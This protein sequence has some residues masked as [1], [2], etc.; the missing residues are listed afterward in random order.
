MSEFKPEDAYPAASVL[1]GLR[2]RAILCFAGGAALLALRFVAR[3][4]ILA[5]VAGGVVCAVGVGWLMANNPANKKTGA[6]IIAA[7]AL[8]ALSRFPVQHI[9]LFAGIALNVIMMW[10]LATGVRNAISYLVT[11][12]KRYS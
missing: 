6:L 12:G 4:P 2:K 3:T 9:A 1:D 7:G 5:Y 10:L 11:R 8:M